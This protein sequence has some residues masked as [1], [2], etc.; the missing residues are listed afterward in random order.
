MKIF[1]DGWPGVEDAENFPRDGKDEKFLSKR[2]FFPFFAINFSSLFRFRSAPRAKGERERV[3]KSFQ[4]PRWLF[5]N[6]IS[7][8]RG[9]PASWRCFIYDLCVPFAIKHGVEN[10]LQQFFCSA[11]FMVSYAFHSRFSHILGQE[12]RKTHCGGSKKYK[13]IAISFVCL[14]F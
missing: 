11:L 14:Q 7:L 1:D 5:V 8:P 6:N 12:K 3:E 2:N 4:T 9:Q 10:L 13:S